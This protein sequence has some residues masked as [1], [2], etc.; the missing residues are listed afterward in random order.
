MA[1]GNAS[2][3][4]RLKEGIESISDRFDVI[5]DGQFPHPALGAISLSVLRAANSLA[6]PGASN[7]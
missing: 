3:L 5:G 2:L 6:G 1:Q 4:D 7:R